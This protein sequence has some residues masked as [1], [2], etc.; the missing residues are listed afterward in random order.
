MIPNDSVCA[1]VQIVANLFADYL[2]CLLSV[3]KERSVGVRSR[4]G[5]CRLFALV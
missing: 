2:S 5:L 3:I 1:D 4:N